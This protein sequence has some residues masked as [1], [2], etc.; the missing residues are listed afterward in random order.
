MLQIL[1]FNMSTLKVN[2]FSSFTLSEEEVKIGSV[3]NLT[4]LQV[5]QNLLS[6]AAEIKLAQ[7]FDPLNPGEFG[8]QTAYQS[9]KIDLLSYLIENSHATEEAMREELSLNQQLQQN[10]E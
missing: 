5:L 7:V 6:E 9:A 3:F 10:Q 8:I 2:K 4:Q 1:E